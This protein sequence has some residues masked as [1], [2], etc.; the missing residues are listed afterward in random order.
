MLVIG[1]GYVGMEMAVVYHSLGS[2]VTV[3]EMQD[4]IFLATDAQIAKMAADRFKKKGINILTKTK[5]ENAQVTK[6]NQV[7]VSS[8]SNGKS[9]NMI[10][11]L[12]LVAIGH[13]AIT[14]NLGLDKIGV[15]T[16][17]KGFI[18]VNQKMQT[19]FKNIFAVGDCAGRQLLAHKAFREG[20]VAAAV[21]SGLDSEMDYRVVPYAIFT[22]PEVAGVGLTEKEAIDQGYKIKVGNYPYRAS[23]RALGMEEPEGMVKI[24]AEADSDEI[25]A[26]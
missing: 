7:H 4:S 8:T 11:D 14:S 15:Q 5:V 18:Q 6:D 16:D 25:L 1:G 23:G 21:A 3:M 17:A 9:E 12:I 26:P 13:K 2:Q 10:F 19:N 24:I 20:E 22:Q